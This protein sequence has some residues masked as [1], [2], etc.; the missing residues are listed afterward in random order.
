MSRPN[1]FKNTTKEN[2]LITNII[3]LLKEKNLNP[4]KKKDLKYLLSLTVNPDIKKINLEYL[5][6]FLLKYLSPENESLFYE[7]FFQSCELGKLHNVKILLENGFDVNCQNELGETPLHIA[8]AKNDIELIK[9]LIKYEPDISITNYKDRFNA[10]NYAEICG[11]KD[12]IDI[13]KELYEKNKKQEI[14]NEIVEYINNDMNNLNENLKNYLIK[15]SGSFMLSRNNTTNNLDQ[16]QNYNGEIVSMFVDEDKSMSSASNNFNKNIQSSKKVINNESKY[17]NTQTIINESD[18]YEENSPMDSKNLV[19]INNN[20]SQRKNSIKNSKQIST[21]KKL[22][23]SSLKR[24]EENTF[25]N[26]RYSINPSYVQSLTTC[27][28]LNRDHFE[29][30]SP[31]INNKKIDKNKKKESI[32]KFIQE[33]N[34]PKE[35]ANNLI[36]N[37]FDVLDVLISQTKKGIALSYQNLKDIGVKLPGERA[38]I[39]VHLEEISGNFNCNIDKE[40]LY[41]NKIDI[42]NNSLYKFLFRINCEK[43]INDFI[44][45][46]YYNSEL[47]FLQMAS[48]QPLNVDILIE[49]IGLDKNDAKKILDN[50]VEGSKNFIEDI[51]Y[52]EENKEKKSKFIILEENNFKSCD[53]CL[54]F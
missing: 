51:K 49:D 12:I 10:M 29:S 50:L 38:K 33:I 53:M 21:E 37:G 1:S 30:N 14:K 20:S 41:A 23:I 31:M 2:D 44:D 35:Y 40:I 34:L 47:L 11:N 6:I 42:K 19:L 25:N 5:L 22:F 3:S 7:N 36:D 4:S 32:F 26:N 24:K 46:G 52:I 27:H 17:V 9:L 48:R 15:D 43:Y 39:L 8:I 16:I 45:A 28:T 13:I 18:F 54:I